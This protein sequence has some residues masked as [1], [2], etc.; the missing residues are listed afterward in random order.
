MYTDI[1][2]ATEVDYVTYS[3]LKLH[4]GLKVGDLKHVGGENGR[5]SIVTNVT[6]GLFKL[7]DYIKKSGL[8]AA[9]PLCTL[10]GAVLLCLE[11][12]ECEVGSSNVLSSEAESLEKVLCDSVRL[13]VNTGV[14]KNDLTAWYS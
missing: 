10:S 11:L 9:K 14:V 2:E 12:E 6:A 7:T 3:A 1:N 8:T 13:G 5:G 4:T